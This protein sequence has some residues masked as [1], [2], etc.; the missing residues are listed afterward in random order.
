CCRVGGALLVA[1]P[2]IGDAFFLRRHG[3]RGDRE[4]YDPEQVIDPLLLEAP[5]D[6]GGAIDLAHRFPLAIYCSFGRKIMHRWQERESALRS[7]EPCVR[8]LL[9]RSFG[10][11]MPRTNRQGNQPITFPRG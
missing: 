5:R 11:A 10:S 7:A 8:A 3:D 4:A 6:Q 1:H 2:E 9:A